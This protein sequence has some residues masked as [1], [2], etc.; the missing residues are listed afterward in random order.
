M[1]DKLQK[2]VSRVFGCILIASLEGFARLGIWLVL[3]YYISITLEVF[4]LNW[5]NFLYSHGR[6]TSSNLGQLD[7]G[8]HCLL[9]FFPL[10]YDLMSGCASRVNGHLSSPAIFNRLFCM[11]FFF[12][13]LFIL[14]WIEFQY[15]KKKIIRMTN[16]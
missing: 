4:K 8:I 6:S 5:M 7:S 3:I 2:Q 14:P 9:I 15:F 10:T 16:V 13:W 11:L 12:K 1:L